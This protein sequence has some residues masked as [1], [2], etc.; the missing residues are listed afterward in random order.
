MKI[1][2]PFFEVKGTS[3]YPDDVTNFDGME[4]VELDGE[5]Y[6]VTDY[7][8]ELN[9]ETGTHNYSD[10]EGSLSPNLIPVIIGDV[11]NQLAGFENAERQYTV[12]ELSES[13]AT[14]QLA[15]PDQKF[16]VPFL[17]VD[18]GRV[19]IMPAEVKAGQFSITL[20]FKTSGKWVV[21]QELLNSEL[22][23][24]VFSIEEHTFWVI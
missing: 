18:T 21:N 2:L 8:G 11:T 6:Y 23:T 15:I 22:P 10:Y 9:L 14:G 7:S 4:E 13:L 16:R 20:N 12:A 19:Q 17:R 1:L 24:P 5:K 3:S